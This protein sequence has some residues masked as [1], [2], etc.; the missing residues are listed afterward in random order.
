MKKFIVYENNISGRVEFVKE[1]FSWPGLFFG[2]LWLIYKRF[3]P[4]AIIYFLIN[5]TVIL[6]LETSISNSDVSDIINLISSIILSIVTGMYGNKLYR[7]YLESKGFKMIGEVY[8]SN[9]NEAAFRT[10]KAKRYNV[11]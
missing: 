3:W 5:T 2:I 11:I 4:M 9:K 10:M 7:D 6:Y 8:A 1:G